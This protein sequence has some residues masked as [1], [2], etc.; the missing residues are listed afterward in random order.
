ML[1]KSFVSSFALLQ[2]GAARV[3]FL[4]IG[5]AGGDFGC[6]IDGSCPTGS[7]QLPLRSFNLGGGD[8]EGQMKHFSQDDG[9][10]LFRLPISWQSLVNNQLGARLDASNLAKYD[11]LVQAC[12]ATGAHCMIDIHNFARWNGGIIGQGGPTDEQFVSLWTQLATKYAGSANI[13]FELMNEPHDLDVPTW[14]ATCQKVITAIRSA[15]ALKQMILLPGTNFDSAAHLVGSGSAQALMALTNPDG[16][17]DN[18]LLDVHKYLDE[19][20]SGTHAACVTNNTDAFGEVAAFLRQAGRKAIVSETGAAPAGSACMERFCEQNAFINAN[21]DVFVGL[22]AWAAGSFDTSYI[23]GLTPSQKNG[24]YVDNALATKCV[25]GTWLESSEFAPPAVSSASAR[26]SSS[27]AGGSGSSS[28]VATSPTTT[29]STSVEVEG[30]V[31]TSESTVIEASTPTPAPTLTTTALV[32]S[33]GLPLPAT[34]SETLAGLDAPNTVTGTIQTTATRN[35]V[36]G[37]SATKSTVTSGGLSRAVSCRGGLVWFS[38][39][40]GFVATAGLF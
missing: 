2:L 21:S 11:K 30:G 7:T 36:P 24:K 19:D 12:L 38:A 4:G 35:L 26:A 29:Q 14:A 34:V 9:M 8:G 10:N 17:T 33:S 27:S 6:E 5:I 13:V 1:I 40:V 20:N 37:A 3:Q 16:T 31:S 15:G 39:V 28:A 18:L 32:V 22:V 25:V 23:L